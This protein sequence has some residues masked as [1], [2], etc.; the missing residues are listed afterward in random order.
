MLNLIQKLLQMDAVL[1]P[2]PGDGN[3]MLWSFWAHYRCLHSETF[4]INFNDK[5]ALKEI[6]SLR[7]CFQKQ[8]LAVSKDPTWQNIFSLTNDSFMEAPKT[9]PKKKKKANQECQQGEFDSPMKEKGKNNKSMPDASPLKEKN[10]KDTNNKNMPDASPPKEEN[11]ENPKDNKKRMTSASPPKQNEQPKKKGP[12]RVEEGKPAQKPAP[13]PERIRL[14]RPGPVDIRTIDEDGLEDSEDEGEEEEETTFG[15]RRKKHTRVK[16]KMFT[17]TELEEQAIREYLG[18][19][20]L[21][22]PVWISAHRRQCALP[23]A[24]VCVDG[25]YRRYQIG[26][27]RG[28]Q[29]L[30]QTCA[31]L[32]REFGVNVEDA[33]KMMKDAVAA[34]QK[35]EPAEDPAEGEGDGDEQPDQPEDQGR[36]LEACLSYLKSLEP[37]ISPVQSINLRNKKVLGYRC[38]LCKTRAQPDGKISSITRLTVGFCKFFVGRHCRTP[39]HRGNLKS[40]QT[41]EEREAVPCPGL[42]LNRVPA[43]S[44]IWNEFLLWVSHTQLNIN[45][46]EHQYWTDLSDGMYFVRHSKCTKEVLN[47]RRDNVCPMCRSLVQAKGVVRRCVVRFNLKFFAAQLLCRNFFSSHEERDEYLAAFKEKSFYKRNKGN[48]EKI[49]S[50]KSTELQ[51]FVATSFRSTPLASRSQCMETFINSTVTPCLKVH[52]GS[53]TEMVPE[54]ANKFLRTLGRHNLTDSEKVNFDIALA[55][56]SGRLESNPFVMGILVKCIKHLE[57]EERGLHGTIGRSGCNDVET[58]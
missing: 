4:S 58:W 52:P 2:V 15:T 17:Q 10:P 13:V 34:Y 20:G 56:C 44:D 28:K 38:N 55:A 43:L 22:Y 39:T 42:C 23:K 54:F 19:C 48:L 33:Q 9:P 40:G 32:N 46:T 5:D 6:D 8:W 27:R 37:I 1:V 35:D 53:V 29:G 47:V 26:L 7:D 25:T 57:R 41:Q 50:L 49:E 18:D 30:C 51:K 21:L 16:K 31:V 45:Q 14:R 11:E 12:R 24:G 36:G 3:C